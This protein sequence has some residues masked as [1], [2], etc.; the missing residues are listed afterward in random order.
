MML[1]VIGDIYHDQDPTLKEK[2][3]KDYEEIK[4]KSTSGAKPR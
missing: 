2:L 1:R 3:L 4:A